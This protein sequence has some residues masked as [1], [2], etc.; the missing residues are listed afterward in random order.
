MTV[1]VKLP[2]LRENREELLQIIRDG[3]YTPSPVRRKGNPKPDES[4][5]RKVGIPT[6]VDRIIQQ[7]IRKVKGY[8]E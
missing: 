3:R 5:V 7:A 1:E 8:P 2:W 4:G 6:V